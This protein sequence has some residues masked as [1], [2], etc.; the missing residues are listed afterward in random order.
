MSTDWT[1][2]RAVDFALAT[3]QLGERFYHRMA[4]RFSEHP[5]VSQVF[6][7]LAEDEDQHHQQFARLLEAVEDD[8]AGQREYERQ[9]V[10]R[11]EAQQQFFSRAAGPFANVDE[12]ET[13]ADALSC[14]FDFEKAAVE[15][16]Q[17]LQEL[18][19]HPPVLESIVR[20]EKEHVRTLLTVLT[21]DGK[22]RGLSDRWPHDRS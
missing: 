11:L 20:A 21:A 3:E 8:S 6:R 16:Y 15:F 13:P 22:F 4:N 5:D 14:A 10:L 1:P 2:K 7:Q 12:V 17:S 19:G 9:Q 18:L